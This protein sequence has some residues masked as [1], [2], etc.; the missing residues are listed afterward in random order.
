M[1]QQPHIDLGYTL[2]AAAPAVRNHLDRVHSWLALAPTKLK[3]NVFHPVG[4]AGHVQAINTPIGQFQIEEEFASRDTT[5]IGK[6]VFYRPSSP[7]RPKPTRVFSLSIFPD[8]TVRLGDRPEDEE[9]EVNPIGDWLPTNLTRIGY[10]LMV[11]GT[12]EAEE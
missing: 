12:T 2:T 7:L 10:A 4:Q 8:G 11:R 5:L 9:M 1:P 6:L 3:G